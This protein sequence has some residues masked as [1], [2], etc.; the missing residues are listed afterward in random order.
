M[1]ETN[2]S[3]AAVQ[4]NTY[5]EYGVPG[6]GNTSRFGYTGQMWIAET[7]LYHYLGPSL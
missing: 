1:A 6:S 2:A 3:G 7:G 5:D 4:I